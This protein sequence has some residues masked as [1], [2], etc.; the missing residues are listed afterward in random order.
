M[1]LGAVA[2][3]VGKHVTQS[4]GKY[5]SFAEFWESVSG[6]TC[7]CV[8]ALNMRVYVSDAECD[9]E[10]GFMLSLGT[11]CPVHLDTMQ[12]CRMSQVSA[13]FT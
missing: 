4:V 2:M 11:H 3:N 8:N 13:F 7:G 6:N 9:I 12:I 1:W 5:V 10:C